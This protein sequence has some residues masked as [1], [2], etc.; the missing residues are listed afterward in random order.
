MKTLKVAEI[1]SFTTDGKIIVTDPCYKIDS[2]SAIKLRIK[3]GEYSAIIEYGVLKKP[4]FSWDAVPGNFRVSSITITHSN[5]KNLVFKKHRHSVS[6]DSG[7]AGFFNQKDY[8][9][10]S[11]EEVELENERYYFFKESITTHWLE[12]KRSKASLR[13]RDK[14]ELYAR[15]KKHFKGSDKDT[16]KWFRDELDRSSRRLKDA[17]KVLKTENYPN[18]IEL[19]KSRAFYDI[20]CNLTKGKND[21]GVFHAGAVSLSGEGD[22]G[23]TLLTAKDPRGVIVAVKIEFISRDEFK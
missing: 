3:P 4:L 10:E 21:A 14:N 11:T 13:E 19:K 16:K 20:V 17:R 5:A 2:D 7:Q 18:Y 8:Q 9:K 1:G 6:V 15:M 22:G 12:I 23:Y